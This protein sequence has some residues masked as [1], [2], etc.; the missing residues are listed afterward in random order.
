MER[1]MMEFDRNISSELVLYQ[2]LLDESAVSLLMNWWLQRGND[3]NVIDLTGS[4]CIDLTREN[5]S[6][7]SKSMGVFRLEKCSFA[8]ETTV[9]R[10]LQFIRAIG[11]E[12]KFISFRRCPHHLPADPHSLL[13]AR[14]LNGIR[15]FYFLD[16][17]F[18]NNV[19]LN[20]R[21]AKFLQEILRCNACK[22]RILSLV[23]C[24]FDEDGYDFFLQGITSH[25]LGIKNLFLQDGI[26]DN[27]RLLLLAQSVK[28]SNS[29]E[30]LEMIYLT[31]NGLS[32]GSL[33]ALSCLLD[34]C[35]CLEI[36][37]LSQNYDLFSDVQVHDSGYSYFLKSLSAH[38]TLEIVDLA[39][40]GQIKDDAV[41][42]ALFQSLEG[43]GL[44]EFLGLPDGS[45]ISTALAKSLPN[46]KM[47]KRLRSEHEL[48]LHTCGLREAFQSHTCLVKLVGSN[49]ALLY[50]GMKEILERNRMLS[51]IKR[52]L[53]NQDELK[54]INFPLCLER[55][56]TEDSHYRP[57]GVFSFLLSSATNWVEWCL[58]KGKKGT[59][60]APLHQS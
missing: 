21:N 56:D 26:L 17:L 9:D 55:L 27:A 51:L 37:D 52:L 30:T 8:D 5:S 45:S 60:R 48:D 41:A 31:E 18:L 50:E 49:N 7:K 29:A 6:A 25:R 53:K 23:R 33:P 13:D 35:N 3:R 40:C 20:G 15:D 28:C 2:I 24:I 54:P 32:P 14:F 43:L 57:S 22:I 36:L 12:C 58:E 10:T 4:S 59:K 42:D 47:L 19:Y 16:T 44:L 46:L 1:Q 39:W 38:S 11:I 34:S